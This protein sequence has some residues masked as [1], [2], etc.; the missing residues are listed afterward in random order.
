MLS[1]SVQLA[2]KVVFTIHLQ[3]G[4]KSKQVNTF[5]WIWMVAQLYCSLSSWTKILLFMR[6]QVGSPVLTGLQESSD[7][8]WI[9]RSTE[10]RAF[11]D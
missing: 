7:F 3:L 1:F 11:L 4:A 5:C 8:K 10:A 2:L 9:G 6:S